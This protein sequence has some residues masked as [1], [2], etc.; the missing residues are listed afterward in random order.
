MKVGPCPEARRAQ[1]RLGR[2][3]ESEGEGSNLFPATL[4]RVAELHCAGI[5]LGFISSL[6]R[7]FVTT[8]YRAISRAPGSCV[9]VRCGPNSSVDGFIAGTVSTHTMFAW[10]LR[11]YGVQLLIRLMLRLWSPAVL[12]RAVETVA[13]VGRRPGKGDRDRARSTD[14]S[15]GE[16]LAIAVAPSCRKKGVGRGLVAEFEDFLR[17]QSCGRY[18]VV[19]HGEDDSSNSFYLAAGFSLDRTFHHHGRVMNEY[20]KSVMPR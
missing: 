15:E 20:V 17:G 18:K 1:A 4:Q 5:R 2:G 9:I 16:L 3:M 11:R 19:T 13:Y 14:D 8:M 10:I 12:R 7:P 6:G